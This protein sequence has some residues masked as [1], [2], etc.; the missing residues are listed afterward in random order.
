MRWMHGSLVL[1]RTKK[2]CKPVQS[3]PLVE[4]EGGGFMVK[5]SNRI[6]YTVLALFLHNR[7]A[8]PTWMECNSKIFKSGPVILAKWVTAYMAWRS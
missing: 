5:Y 6:S 3:F 8:R 4:V 7:S 1:K 2:I